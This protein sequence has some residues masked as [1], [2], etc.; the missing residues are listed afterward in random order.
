MRHRHFTCYGNGVYN[1]TYST[2]YYLGG[3]DDSSAAAPTDGVGFIPSYTE[4][5]AGTAASIADGIVGPTW[6]YNYMV[7]IGS[8]ENTSPAVPSFFTLYDILGYV[9]GSAAQDSTA[10]TTTHTA[11]VSEQ[12]LGTNPAC[13]TVVPDSP[14]LPNLTFSTT[15]T[16]AGPEDDDGIAFESTMSPDRLSQGWYTYQAYNT[17]VSRPDQ[18]SGNILLPDVTPEPSTM[19]LLGGAMLGLGLFHRRNRKNQSRPS[20]PALLD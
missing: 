13:C 11:T 4:N 2:F 6:T 16:L 20:S 9:A 10:V 3:G 8:D 14:S 18:G 17:S 15:V 12:L 1:S 19:A 5:L 7:E